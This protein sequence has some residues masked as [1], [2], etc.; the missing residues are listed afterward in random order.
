MEILIATGAG[1]TIINTM[2]SVIAAS[3]NTL[4]TLAEDDK[5]LYNKRLGI[6]VKTAAFTF[7]HNISASRGNSA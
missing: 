4:T 1:D 5:I 7:K 2:V 6:L 3:D